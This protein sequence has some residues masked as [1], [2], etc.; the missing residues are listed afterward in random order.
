MTLSSSWDKNRVRNAAFLAVVAFALG[1]TG[2][3]SNSSGVSFRVT[4]PKSVHNAPLN[5]RLQLV[6]SKDGSREPRMQVSDNAL[7]TQQMFGVNVDG[8]QPDGSAVLNAD[9][10]GYPLDK[11]QQI[12]A[13][14]Y[15]VQAVFNVY[16]TVHRADGHELK[17]PMD[18]WEGQQWNTKPGNLYST[19]RQIWIDPKS[20]GTI[21]ISLDKVVPEK[22]FPKDT[23]YV[24]YV[25][26]QSKLLSDFWGRPMFLG[27]FVILPEGFDAHPDA[28]YPLIVNPAHFPTN[29]TAFSDQPPDPTLVDS[30]SAPFG[31]GG[32]GTGPTAATSA[33]YAY[34]FYQYW[35]SD[36]APRMLFMAI[37]HPTPYYDDSYGVNSPNNGPYGDAITQELIPEV[38]KKFRGI[39]QTW[40]RALT[41]CSTGG[42]EALGMQVF[43]PDFYNGTWAGAP[44]PID[45]HSWRLVNIYANKNAYYDEGPFGHVPIPGIGNPGPTSLTQKLPSARMEDNNVSATMEQDNRIELVVGDHGRG[46]GLWDGM[47]AVFGPVAADG[48]PGMIWD[49]KTGAINPD[50]AK[51]WQDHSDI[52]HILERD[53]PT[54]GPKLVGKIHLTVGT[55]DQWYLAN[56]VRRVDKILQATKNPN[57]GGS[58][59][60]GDRF[61]HCWVG[62]PNDP[63]AMSTRTVYERQMPEMADRMVKTAPAGADVKSWKY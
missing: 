37:Q 57:Y 6:L 25:R 18:H 1:A 2:C 20:G 46:G 60:Y 19:P 3:Q 47:Q 42:W 14:A 29:I 49:K 12:P 51:Y 10:I 59:E 48:Y 45:F 11:L 26:I 35:K 41:G 15:Y 24:K 16:E 17:L 30:D 22:P 58:V 50:V 39:G 23:K 27:A 54:L 44:S 31:D 63:E 13:G 8:L 32:P 53:W 43:Y 62:D 56:A 52:G 55:S 7:T 5:G 33:K 61:V 9:A 28:H 40:A 34:Q 36:K 38:E 21:D 4:M